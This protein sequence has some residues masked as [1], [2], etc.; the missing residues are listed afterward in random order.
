[1]KLNDAECRIQELEALLKGAR[2]RYRDCREY[3]KKNENL[4][5]NL[6]TNNFAKTFHSCVSNSNNNVQQCVE[7]LSGHVTNKTFNIKML[8]RVTS[9]THNC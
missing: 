2:N 5:S 6:I 3:L 7:R 4:Y 1:M 9:K 8:A